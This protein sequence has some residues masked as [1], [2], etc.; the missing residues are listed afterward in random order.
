MSQQSGSERYDTKIANVLNYFVFIGS[1][2]R[3]DAGRLLYDTALNSTISDL[4]NDYGL[5]FEKCW[6]VV[7]NRAGGM[8]R[9]KRYSLNSESA[10]K[11][12][13]LLKHWQ[14]KP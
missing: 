12:L 6:E 3:F 14:V 2:N 9:V 8:T 7:P 5:S 4:A 11:A 13:K 1:L 10:E